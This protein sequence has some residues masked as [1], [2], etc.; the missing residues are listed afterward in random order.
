[1]RIKASDSKDIEEL[2][3]QM[4]GIQD[5][6]SSDEVYR[7]VK[8]GMEGPRK[9]R[10]A[11]SFAVTAIAGAAVVLAAVLISPLLIPQVQEEAGRHASQ[12]A[13]D[14]RIS[15]PEKTNQEKRSEEQNSREDRSALQSSQQER[16][17]KGVGADTKTAAYQ[18]DL[19]KGRILKY[20]MLTSDAIVVPVSILAGNEKGKD[21]FEVYEETGENISAEKYGFQPIQPFFDSLDYDHE[22]KTLNIVYKEGTEDF[23]KANERRIMDMISYSFSSEEVRKVRF[24]NEDGTSQVRSHY[25]EGNEGVPELPKRRGYYAYPLSGTDN[26]YL[27]PSDLDFDSLAEAVD[28]MKTSP[29]DFYEPILTDPAEVYEDSTTGE[30]AVIRFTKTFRL[31]QSDPRTSMLQIEGLLLAARDFGY[32][33]VLFQNIEPAVWEGFHF[34]EPVPVPVAPNLLR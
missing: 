30:R 21:W 11:R 12:K 23:L 31:D 15:G 18:E 16:S 13:A 19:R 26:V 17:M 8:L 10:P 33:S 6:R 28:A 27:V 7:S 22:G 3:K 20:G 5:R 25:G 24:L 32:K 4:P 1:M 29:N 34:D 9:R 2:L 14:E